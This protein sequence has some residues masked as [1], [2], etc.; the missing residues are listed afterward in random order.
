MRGSIP[1]TAAN[2]IVALTYARLPDLGRDVL[3]VTNNPDYPSLYHAIPVDLN[4]GERLL[5]EWIKN[6]DTSNPWYTYLNGKFDEPLVAA[7]ERAAPDAR[8]RVGVHAFPADME[9]VYLE[10]ERLYPEVRPDF[11]D[12]GTMNQ[13]Y[14]VSPDLYAEMSATM[15]RIYAARQSSA[16]EPIVAWLQAED[17]PQ[18]AS[19]ARSSGRS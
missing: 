2:P 18:R 7:L 12:I 4:S 11:F 10:L 19:A 17:A 3:F 9:L 6:A 13:L 14:Q 15:A 1:G 8:L 5:S 16:R